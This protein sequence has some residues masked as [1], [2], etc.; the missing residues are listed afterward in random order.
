MSTFELIF[1]G[2][3]LALVLV[4]L[5]LSPSARR[6]IVEPDYSIAE[7]ALLILAFLGGDELRGVTADWSTTYTVAAFVPTIVVMI[8]LVI[9][10]AHYR[11][12]W[13][14][15]PTRKREEPE[16]RAL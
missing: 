2:V 12:K 13:W 14:N 15:T 8:A 3:V 5:V 10:A 11:F 16:E 7:V 6:E 9:V 1:V 4:V